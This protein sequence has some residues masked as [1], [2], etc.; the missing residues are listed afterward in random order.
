MPARFVLRADRLL[1][2]RGQLGYVTVNTLVEGAT[3]RV[4]LSRRPSRG[5]TIRAGRSPHP[6]PTASANLQI[7]EIWA[8]RALRSR[9]RTRAGR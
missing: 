6:W 9:G 3:L 8:S 7:V 2:A 4:G 1:S 5:L